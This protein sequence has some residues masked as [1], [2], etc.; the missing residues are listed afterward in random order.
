MDAKRSY[1]KTVD[2]KD[3]LTI[4]NNESVFFGPKMGQTKCKPLRMRYFL[5]LFMRY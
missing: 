5:T 1:F 2:H 3:F 4:N